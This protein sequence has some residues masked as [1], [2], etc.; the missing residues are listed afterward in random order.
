[1]LKFIILGFLCGRNMSGYEIKQFMRYS[2]SNFVNASFGSIYPA[3]NSLEKEGSVSFC[4][5][6]E[7]GKYSKQYSITEVGKETFLKWLREPCVFSP[8]NYEYLAKMFFYKLLTKNEVLQLLDTF[9]DSVRKEVEKIKEIEDT[10]DMCNLNFYEYATLRF[11]RDYYNM[12]IQ[13]HKQLSED[14]I[15]EE[16]LN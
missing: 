4:E 15:K 5:I 7:G 8:F 14:L 13:W 12:V 2:T 10:H 9:I 6:V 16:S 3:L 11:G 1:M